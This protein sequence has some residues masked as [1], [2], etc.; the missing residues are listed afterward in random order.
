LPTHP[1]LSPM[2]MD[3]DCGVGVKLVVGEKAVT[4]NPMKAQSL[5]LEQQSSVMIVTRDKDKL[6]SDVVGAKQLDGLSAIP[7]S[8]QQPDNSA[9]EDS[10]ILAKVKLHGAVD[11]GSSNHPSHAELARGDD[12]HQVAREAS[13]AIPN[14]GTKNGKKF[15]KRLA[16][17]KGNVFGSTVEGSKRVG[18]LC[19]VSQNAL[20]TKRLKVSVDSDDSTFSL[21]VEAATQPR[22]DQ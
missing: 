5:N 21:S 15:W 14:K 6:V 19:V 2:C 20:V 4:G 9:T 1:G 18:D 7:V 16:C 17:E 3:K 12:M 13:S 11:V 8:T 22:R 10:A